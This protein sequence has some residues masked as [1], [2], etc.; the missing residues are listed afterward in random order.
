MDPT[1][2]RADGACDRSAPSP[3]E[4]GTK[5]MTATTAIG[6][7]LGESIVAQIDRLASISESETD[8]TRIFLSPEHRQAADL[9]RSWMEDAGMAARMDAIGNVIGRYEGDQPKLP[10]LLLGSLYDTVRNAG[11]WDGPLGVVSAIACVA[12][13]YLHGAMTWF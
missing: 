2:I 13:A 4:G 8:L 6:T 7:A 11:K 5:G 10:A 1:P 12:A 9:I 3:L